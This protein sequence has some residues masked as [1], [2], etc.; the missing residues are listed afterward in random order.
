MH[1]RISYYRRR[2]RE[3]NGSVRAGEKK[4]MLREAVANCSHFLDPLI[5][6]IRRLSSNIILCL[7]ISHP[8]SSL[9]MGLLDRAFEMSCSRLVYPTC[10]S[11]R[12]MV[13]GMCLGVKGKKKFGIKSDN[14][15]WSEW[16]GEIPPS[17]IQHIGSSSL[18]VRA[19]KE[20]EH[21]IDWEFIRGIFMVSLTMYVFL[22]WH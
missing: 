20:R 16:N 17:L 22:E 11:S 13:L 2:G 18:V 6:I 9:P 15:H 21:W 7:S 4:K 8:L 10:P 3:E 12:Y 5:G 19:K 1:F 14:C